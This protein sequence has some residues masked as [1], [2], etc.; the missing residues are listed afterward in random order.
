MDENDLFNEFFGGLNKDKE[1]EKLT[2]EQKLGKEL[3][4]IALLHPAKKI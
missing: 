3:L 4:R 1:E 2:P